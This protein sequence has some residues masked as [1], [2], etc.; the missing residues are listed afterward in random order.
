MTDAEWSAMTP[1]Q[2]DALVRK[3]LC[4]RWRRKMKVLNR[5]K[6]WDRLCGRIRLLFGF[7]PR[8]NSDSPAVHTCSV[9]R[10]VGNGQGSTEPN[11]RQQWPPTLETKALWWYCWMHA[12]FYEMQRDHERAVLRAM[13]AENG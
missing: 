1:E 3:V 4:G 10:N 6:R 2:Q 9:C 7:C 8:C 12:G 5:D 11:R 13:E